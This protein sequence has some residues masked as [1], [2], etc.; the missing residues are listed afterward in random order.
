M[1]KKET[2][3]MRTDRRKVRIQIN[4][5]VMKNNQ[6]RAARKW[7]ARQTGHIEHIL[8]IFF[9]QHGLGFVIGGPKAS[10]STR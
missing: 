1:F 4:H 5:L 6:D 10:G 3:Y 7:T 9:P 2:A 8:F